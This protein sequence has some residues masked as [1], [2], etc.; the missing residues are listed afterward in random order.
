MGGA[1]LVSDGIDDRFGPRLREQAP[2]RA[3]LRLEG[4]DLAGGDPSQVEIAFFSADLF[5]DRSRAL[6]RALHQAPELRWFHSF[7]AGVDHPW[8]QRFL[9]RGAPVPRAE[10]Q[11]A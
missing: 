11:E 10:V 1:I 5:P 8:F 4:E 3:V 2:D 6:A 7:A 9:E